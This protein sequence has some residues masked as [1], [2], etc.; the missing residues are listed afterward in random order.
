MAASR[1]RT[2]DGIMKPLMGLFPFFVLVLLVLFTAQIS[3]SQNDDTDLTDKTCLEC[4]ETIEVNGQ[5]I[6]VAK[7]LASSIHVDLACIDCHAGI[8][9]LEHEDGVAPVNCGD[10][11]SEEAADYQKHGRL[12]TGQDKDLPRC[13]SCHGT[14]NI[15]PS[16]EEGSRVSHKNLPS[17]CGACHE[18]IDL[19]TKHENLYGEAVTLYKSSVHGKAMAGGI[20][21]AAICSDCHFVGG[22][23]HKIYDAGDKRSK[24]NYFNIPTT[25]GNCHKQEAEDYWE[26]I[27]GKLVADGKTGSPVCTKCHGEHGIISPSDPRSS[28]SASRVAEV[29]CSPCHESAYL[30]ERLTGPDGKSRNWYD[31]YHGVKSIEGD[32]TVANCA[33]CHEAHLILPHTDPKSSIFAENLQ[34][35]CGK[36]HPGISAQMA[37]TPIHQP[38]GIARTP[39][40]AVVKN[41]YV[42]LIIVVVG[43]MILY[44]LVDYRRYVQLSNLKPQIVRMTRSAVW[45]H[46]FLIIAFTVLI[47]SG[48]ALRH[49]DAWWV[50]ILFGWEGGFGLRG[51]IHRVTAVLFLV[52]VFWHLFHLSTRQGRKFFKDMLPGVWD[53]T[54]LMQ[55]IRFNLGM[56]SQRPAFGRFSYV[57][58]VEYWALAWGTI[59]MAVTGLMLWFDNEVVAWFSEAF[60]DVMLVIHYYEAWL[61]MLAVLVW[62]LYSTVF[63]P[64]VYPMNAAWLTGKMEAEKYHEEHSGDPALSEKGG[65]ESATAK[66]GMPFKGSSPG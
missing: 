38:P 31:S 45:Q 35:T 64:A 34:H 62:H 12:Q 59:I 55:M 6:D 54:Q 9:S 43:G 42:V 21:T 19:T 16:S 5:E 15:L 47:L 44:C 36:C 37:S 66:T 39:A 41:I 56:N 23:A 63:N 53:V 58:K 49:G 40:A 14:H 46:A 10:C 3:I 48:F 51:T 20:D 61:A 1:K 11:H 32:I 22:S 57:E 52:T 50:N 18:N 7:H 30:N 13:A 24:T 29:T 28:V 17:T 25:C 2:G 26:G 4:H 33:S 8:T 60:L 27:H 65:A